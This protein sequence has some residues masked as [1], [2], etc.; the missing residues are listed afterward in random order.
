M[1]NTQKVKAMGAMGDRALVLAVLAI[2]ASSAMADV[3]P[4]LMSICALF[5]VHPSC[6]WPEASTVAHCHRFLKA[7]GA[8]H[9]TAHMSLIICFSGAGSDRAAPTCGRLRDCSTPGGRVRW[10]AWRRC[11]S[12]RARSLDHSSTPTGQPYRVPSC[13][14]QRWQPSIVLC[15][16]PSCRCGCGWTRRPLACCARGRGR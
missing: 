15:Q 16:P 8:S 11:K 3:R 6:R 14:L 2:S 12:A 10:Y 9:L 5:G 7:A 13:S 4:Y 1:F